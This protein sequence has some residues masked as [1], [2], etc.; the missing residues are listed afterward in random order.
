MKNA[1]NKTNSKDLSA[2]SP[3]VILPYDNKIKPINNKKKSSKFEMSSFKD[4]SIQKM[5]NKNEIE[6]EEEEY[7]YELDQTKIDEDNLNSIK[8]SNNPILSLHEKSNGDI[9]NTKI[10]NNNFD[11][12]NDFPRQIKIE[13]NN[14]I[15]SSYKYLYNTS[16]NNKNIEQFIKKNNIDLLLFENQNLLDNK[17]I[18]KSIILQQILIIE[19]MKEIENLKI[20][21]NHL[22]NQFE[23]AKKNIIENYEE[24]INNILINK[25]ND[26]KINKNN[27]INENIKTDNG[28]F[29]EEEYKKKFNLIKEQTLQDLK[30]KQLLK[31]NNDYIQNENKNESKILKVIDNFYETIKLISNKFKTLIDNNNNIFF[32]KNLKDFINNINVDNNGNKSINDKLITLNEFNNIIYLELDI[33]FNYIKDKKIS[34]DYAKNNNKYYDNNKYYNLNTL[35]NLNDSGNGQNIIVNSNI[36]TNKKKYYNERV[37]RKID[38]IINKNRLTKTT[39]SKDLSK[40]DHF[41]HYANTF[42]NINNNIEN[43]LKNNNNNIFI[44]NSNLLEKNSV[45]YKSNLSPPPNDNKDTFINNSNIDNFS[46]KFNELIKKIL[47]KDEIEKIK[48]IQLNRKVNELNNMRTSNKPLIKDNIG[49]DN[50]YSL[51]K[52]CKKIKIPL[53]EKLKINNNVNDN[54]I[55]TNN[56]TLKEKKSRSI[57]KNNSGLKN[58]NNLNFTSFDNMPFLTNY[59]ETNYKSKIPVIENYNYINKKNERN[60]I[61]ELH[62]IKTDIKNNNEYLRIKDI[63]QKLNNS[64]IL[65]NSCNSHT[66][67]S[68]QYLKIPSKNDDLR[69][70]KIGNKSFTSN[71][72]NSICLNIDENINKKFNPKIYLKQQKLKHKIIRNKK[73]LNNNFIRH[74]FLKNNLS[75]TLNRNNLEKDKQ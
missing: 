49:N 54:L 29:K 34:T 14:D 48:N 1:S 43:N 10:N 65:F 30:I 33:L 67:E 56:L 74:S 41:I 27:Y 46:L 60:K 39:K 4:S 7:G 6:K 68:F 52:I 69:T 12:D 58:I 28:V 47:N 32:N 59:K 24:K 42:K 18:K 13:K 25:I 20:E 64:N 75:L 36:N 72:K 22:K 40:K 70:E 37:F 50:K 17:E 63:F 23:I 73:G 51:L 45:V 44:L 35:D 2:S 62:Y 16:L 55:L 61:N 71:D 66:I 53:P 38:A 15:I 11:K 3:K 5:N 31:E 21:K 8:E 57:Y 26:I 9:C 19:M